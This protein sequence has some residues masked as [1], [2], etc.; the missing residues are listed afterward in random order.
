M[1]VI[2]DILSINGCKILAKQSLHTINHMNSQIPESCRGLA[3]KDIRRAADGGCIKDGR[4]IA[5]STFRVFPLG[6]KGTED[7]RVLYDRPLRH[8][9]L[10]GKGIKQD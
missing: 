6:G 5:H 3:G 4:I 2:K 10:D 7:E 9:L 8:L 1:G